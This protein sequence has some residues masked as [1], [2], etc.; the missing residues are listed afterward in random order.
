[1][2]KYPVL[3]EASFVEPYVLR[4]NYENDEVRIYDFEA[5][6][7]HPFYAPLKSV[8]LFKQVYVKNGD[9]LWPTGQDFCPHTLYDQ[10]V[11]A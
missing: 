7:E 10:S 4:L 6:L 8:T 3:K 11:T 1:M 9:L 2:K 5:N